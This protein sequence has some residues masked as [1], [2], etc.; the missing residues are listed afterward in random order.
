MSEP[1]RHHYIPQFILRNFLNENNKLYYWNTGKQ[2]IEER[3]TKSIYM[4]FNLYRDEKNN[5]ENPTIIEKKFSALEGKVANLINNKIIGKRTIKITRDENEL[6]RKYLFL[7]SFRSAARKEQYSNAKFD[8]LTEAVLSSKLVD[9]D[10]EDLWLR[11]LEI[12]LDLKDLKKVKENNDLSIVTQMDIELHLKSYY[13]TI[14]NARGQD[15]ILSDIYPTLGVYE[16]GR[17]GINFNA[18]YFYPLTPDLVLILNHIAFREEV[19]SKDDNFKE[20]VSSSFMKGDLIIAPKHKSK[21][22][23]KFLSDDTYT[24]RVN[25]IYEKDISEINMLILNEVREGFSFRNKDRINESVKKY[26]ES[27]IRNKKLVIQIF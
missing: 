25:N 19:Y 15:V 2:E 1:K 23:G 22:H 9:N 24:Y 5:P 20:I 18:H 12:I 8:P 26:Q 13:M 16:T 6:L 3:N 27:T 7:L 21:I 14:I 10:Y 4:E 17:S 11:E